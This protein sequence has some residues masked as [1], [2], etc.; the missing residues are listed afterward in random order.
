MHILH[1]ST[2]PHSGVSLKKVSMRPSDPWFNGPA[3]EGKIMVDERATRPL[4]PLPGEVG[5][6]TFTGF[7]SSP[8]PRERRTSIVSHIVQVRKLRLRGAL[9]LVSHVVSGRARAG[10]SKPCLQARISTLKNQQSPNP[11][12]L[13]W[14]V[15]L[16]PH[17]SPRS[18]PDAAIL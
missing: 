9:P 17:S 2:K 1:I 6:I 15:V 18:S 12:N 5:S 11:D 14:T 4:L 3:M 7:Q 13:T 10:T 16:P 8:R